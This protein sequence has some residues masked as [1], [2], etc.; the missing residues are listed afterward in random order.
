MQKKIDELLKL[1]EKA[2]LGGGADRI[3][4]QH[5]KGKLSARERVELLVDEGSFEE[6]DAFVKHRGTDFGLSKQHYPGD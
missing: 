6:I 1:R 3:K 2:K 5:D 4:A